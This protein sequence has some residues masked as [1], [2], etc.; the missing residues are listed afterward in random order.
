M[1]V[2]L[3]VGFAAALPLVAFELY[4]FIAPGLSS[5]SRKFGLIALP[6]VTV[7]FIAGMVFAHQVMLPPAM[8]ILLNFMD[9]KTQIRPSS[10]ISFVTGLIF[11]I[12][13]AFEFPFFI[14]VLAALRVVRARMLLNQWRIAIVIIAVMAAAITP[15]IDPVTMSLVMGPMIVLYFLS[16]ALAYLAQRGQA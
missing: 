7:F 15:T 16:I 11:W 6:A 3:T 5:K 12:G 1:R 10:Y 13:V 9:M 4:L 8:N 14:Y 2:A